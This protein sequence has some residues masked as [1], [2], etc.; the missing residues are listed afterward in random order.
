[1]ARHEFCIRSLARGKVIL[2]AG[3]VLTIGDDRAHF[4][5][6]YSWRYYWDYYWP[7]TA[8]A[9]QGRRMV[10]VR[11]GIWKTYEGALKHEFSWTDLSEL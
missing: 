8:A 7:A 9:A 10:L 2:P 6:L 1:M 3:A 11:T 5:V 4:A